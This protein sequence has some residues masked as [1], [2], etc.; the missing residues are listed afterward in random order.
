V[1]L[2]HL[3]EAGHLA[4]DQ[5][6]HEADGEGLVAHDVA[7][8]PDRVAQAFGLL[9]A[10][11]NHGACGGYA[12]GQELELGGLRLALQRL[13]QLGCAV[14]MVL[15]DRLASARDED[16]LLDPRGHRLLQRVLD[17]GPIHD[18]QHLLRQD[19]GGR[20]HAGAQTSDREDHFAN[21]AHP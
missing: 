20:Q 15:K 14:E 11:I 4:L 10:G 13:E 2:D 7:G 3:P 5:I 6:V 19:L 16:E 21:S 1:R 9:L 18:R 12:R 17:N 8:A